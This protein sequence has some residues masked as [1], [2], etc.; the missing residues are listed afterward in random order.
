M[1][2]MR[3]AQYDDVI[4]VPFEHGGRIPLAGPQALAPGRGVDCYGLLMCLYR[5]RGIELP[6]PFAAVPQDWAMRESGADPEAWIAAHLGGWRRVAEPRMGCAAVMSRGGQVADHVG[7]MV[8]PYQCV[9]AVERTGVI[10]SRIDRGPWAVRM[11]G[12]YD[13]GA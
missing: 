8:S 2:L 1:M 6:D 4:G 13:Y 10:L 11:V 7:V 9:H 3:S 12:Y 5:R